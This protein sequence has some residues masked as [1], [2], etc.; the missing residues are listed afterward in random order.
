MVAGPK[1]LPEFKL[2][3]EPLSPQAADLLERPPSVWSELGERHR[4]GGEPALRNCPWPKCPS[5]GE[6]MTFYAQL[7]GLPKPSEFD[8]ADAGLILVF[9]CFDCFQTAAVLDSA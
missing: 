9:I 1:V 7:D 6:R 2:V 5:C 8:L 3:P 4:I